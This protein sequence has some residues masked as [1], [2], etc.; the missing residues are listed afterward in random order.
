M[1]VCVVDSSSKVHARRSVGRG[2]KTPKDERDDRPSTISG[3]KGNEADPG[4]STLRTVTSTVY[5]K[6]GLCRRS[7]CL[8]REVWDLT[9]SHSIYDLRM[10]YRQSKEYK[11]RRKCFRN[12]PVG[13]HALADFPIGQSGCSGSVLVV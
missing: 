3:G 5:S 1:P 7:E 4:I 10:S 6:L 11:A 2:R 8:E 9:S 12:D 13:F